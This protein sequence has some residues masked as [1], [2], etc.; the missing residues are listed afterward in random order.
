[1]SYPY[2]SQENR[3]YPRH[4]QPVPGLA[5]SPDPRPGTRAGAAARLVATSAC[6]GLALVP[7]PLATWDYLGELRTPA[8]L[9][10]CP[11]GTIATVSMSSSVYGSWRGFCYFGR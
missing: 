11:A 5:G 8:R 6:L 7:L 9:E 4:R 1:M 3:T 2:P 10:Q